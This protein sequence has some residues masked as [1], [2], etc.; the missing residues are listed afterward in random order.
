MAEYF[1]DE[2]DSKEEIEFKDDLLNYRGYFVEND[3]EEEKKFY[4]YGAH[5][6]YKFLYQRLEILVQERKEK[7]KELEKKLK[8]KELNSN[9]KSRNAQEKNEESKQRENMKDLL[10]IFQPKGKSRNRGDVDIGLTYM[11]QMNKKKEEQIQVIDEVAIGLIKSTVGHKQ[12]NKNPNINIKNIKKNNIIKNEGLNG[13]NRKYNNYIN[14]NEKKSNILSSRKIKIGNK[15]TKIRK[16]NQNKIWNNN[17]SLN[18]NITISLNL[19][20]KT[21][22]AEKSNSKNMTHDFPFMSKITNNLVNKLKFI[23]YSKEK[24]RKH[25]LNTG[26]TEQNIIKKGKQNKRNN[27]FR[28]INNKG[29]NSIYFGYQNT[30]NTSSS[31]NMVNNNNIKNSLINKIGISSSNNNQVNEK[32][33]KK[34]KI[35]NKNSNLKNNITKNNLLDN[36]NTNNK[37]IKKNNILSGLKNNNNK[38][39]NIYNI[40]KNMA[41]KSNITSKNNISINSINKNSNNI[42]NEKNKIQSINFKN[43]L[44]KKDNCISSNGNRN[45][46]EFIDSFGTK[47]NKNN[48]SRNN[49][50]SIFNNQIQSAANKNFH[51][52]N[53]ANKKI[54]KVIPAHVNINLTKNFNN[55]N[56]QLKTQNS[57]IKEINY[58]SNKNSSSNVNLIKYSTEKIETK[59]I[60]ENNNNKKKKIKKRKILIIFKKN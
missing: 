29:S 1:F 49:K 14:K 48:I 9:K 33:D 52:M 7:Q 27:K 22:F 39:K 30:K 25:I 18:G 11:P 58:K 45:Q 20:N 24:I 50:V 26:K 21:K 4:E 56:Q 46:F 19:F 51:S 23:P 37:F 10:N 47:I 12:E 13:A 36:N 32:L 54:I 53:N 55:S 44:L 34:N 41:K 15:P 35:M 43:M 31:K 6:P 5:F 17:N 28:N 8:E 16:R 42:E 2:D 38:N 60:V 40:N 3:D 59:K 57:K